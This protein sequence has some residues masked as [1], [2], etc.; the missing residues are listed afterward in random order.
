M[1]VSTW[2]TLYFEFLVPFLLFFP[3][4][5]ERVRCFV[6]LSL[7]LM[8]LSFGAF[9]ELGFF[10]Y[11]PFICAAS[12]LPASF[13]NGAE[14]VFV[15]LHN[16]L[17][18][19]PALVVYSDMPPSAYFWRVFLCFGA[20][21]EELVSFRSRIPPSLDS[22]MQERRIPLVVTMLAEGELN[23]TL[24]DVCKASPIYFLPALLFESALSLGAQRCIIELAYAYCK[25]MRASQRSG[26]LLE[27]PKENPRPLDDKDLLTDPN[28]IQTL[29]KL[30]CHSF[31]VFAI[32][33][34]LVWNVNAHL[35]IEQPFVSQRAADVLGLD[36]W[37]GMFAPNPPLTNDWIVV[38]SV[39]RSPSPLSNR[40]GR[41]DAGN[42][43]FGSDCRPL[44]WVAPPFGRPSR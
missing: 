8:H 38:C 37:W 32:V 16:K 40:A 42:V 12:F 23:A 5:T 6:V 17:L 11:I 25:G 27:G 13:W 33:F 14:K 44:S 20:F 9:L 22:I 41:P 2:A 1:K 43:E 19:T 31:L 15:L 29:R 24:L 26:S 34:C 21:P 18:N 4:N 7:T 30:L 3:L 39:I 28:R 36:Q 35:A 10:P